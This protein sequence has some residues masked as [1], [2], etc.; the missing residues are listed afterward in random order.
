MAKYAKE[1]GKRTVKYTCSICGTSYDR[2]PEAEACELKCQKE[3]AE[4][5]LLLAQLE[6]RLEKLNE[7]I[8]EIE[9]IYNVSLT[10][11]F[12]PG[13]GDKPILA[14]HKKINMEV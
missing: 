8:R 10:F 14:A 11:A 5:E 3:K 4:R 9:T 13:C 2:Q 7:E 1:R 12:V 6:P